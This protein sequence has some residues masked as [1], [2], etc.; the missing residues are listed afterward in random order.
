MALC[1]GLMVM[2]YKQTSKVDVFVN[3][4]QV[5]GSE[6]QETLNQTNIE[7]MMARMYTYGC[8][9]VFIQ[10]ISKANTG[11]S[12]AYI[13]DPRHLI[14][15]AH[16]R[17]YD[18]KAF[19]NKMQLFCII[20]EPSDYVLTTAEVM[21]QSM[22]YTYD[23]VD[24]LQGPK[25]TFR[26]FMMIYVSCWLFWIVKYTTVFNK[27]LKDYRHK[28]LSQLG[29][30]AVA[31]IWLVLFKYL[32]G[33]EKLFG[34]LRVFLNDDLLLL[35]RTQLND[36]HTQISLGIWSNT[37]VTIAYIAVNV[38][39]LLSYFRI[40]YGSSILKPNLNLPLTE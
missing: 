28:V 33:Y 38:L 15:G 6:G 39:F 3:L 11:N 24:D 14:K 9:A 22:G 30:I 25:W 18:Y 2:P 32:I 5:Y 17:P 34:A 37:Q 26:I 20:N 1:G 35:L 4:E 10:V 16:F 13:G 27:S 23:Y 31:S 8:D 21:L 40:L 36:W 29:K 7:N 19:P 12:I